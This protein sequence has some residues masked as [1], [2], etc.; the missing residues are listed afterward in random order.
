MDW[1]KNFAEM[2]ERLWDLLIYPLLAMFGITVNKEDGS[3]D[4]K[5]PEAK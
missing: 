3:L 1:S 4:Y 5:E 2:W